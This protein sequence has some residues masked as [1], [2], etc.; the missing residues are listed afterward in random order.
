MEKKQYIKPTIER[1]AIFTNTG[2]YLGLSAKNSQ[3]L[4]LDRPEK[5]A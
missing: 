2:K 3:S 5:S 4:F 1:K